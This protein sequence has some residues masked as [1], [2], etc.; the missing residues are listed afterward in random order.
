[1]AMSCKGQ[2]ALV[3]LFFCVGAQR[4]DC[5]DREGEQL[6]DFHCIPRVNTNTITSQPRLTNRVLW[7]LFFFFSLGAQRRD[8]DD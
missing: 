5:D 2:R 7:C 4:R 6:C 3:C 8:G 1:M